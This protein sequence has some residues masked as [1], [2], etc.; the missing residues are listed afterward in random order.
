MKLKLSNRNLAIA[1]FVLVLFTGYFYFQGTGIRTLFAIALFFFL[2]FFLILRKFKFE[3]DEQVFFAFFIGIGI[4]S[5]I[6]FY[7]GRL[8]PSY[9]FATGIAFIALLLVPFAVKKYL[10]KKN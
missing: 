6:V 3:A 5:T 9:R 8:I 4:F 1:G 2:P 10:K 7:F